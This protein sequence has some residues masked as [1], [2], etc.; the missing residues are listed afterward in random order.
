ML[1]DVVEKRINEVS[2]IAEAL[3]YVLPRDGWT[4]YAYGLLT[5][6]QQLAI[7]L[8]DEDARADG[9]FEAFKE[10]WIT[11]ENGNHIHIG[12]DGNPDKG[13]PYVLAAIKGAIDNTEEKD[14]QEQ[15]RQAKEKTKRRKRYM[16]CEKA[17]NFSNPK[18]LSVDELGGTVTHFNHDENEM[19][20]EKE[21]TA[22][23][24]KGQKFTICVGKIEHLTIFASEE[25]D[26][27]VRKAK[28]LARRVGG[29]A[30]KWKHVK[31]MGYVID[32]K[33]NRKLADLH[34][35]ENPETGQ[36]EWKLKQFREEMDESEVYWE[37]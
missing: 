16:I 21:I 33:G 12:P 5:R 36:A 27:P 19:K 8:D 32:K 13:N 22:E 2:E 24:S 6:L 25:I 10:A 14:K 23:D 31:G 34:W 35:F 15:E 17:V 9:M 3:S 11:S 7:I 4:E 28:S 37:E 29:S 18:E 30:E 1:S 26:R 20:V